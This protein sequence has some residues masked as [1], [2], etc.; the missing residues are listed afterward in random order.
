MEIHLHVYICVLL[1]Q[2][3]R[4]LVRNAT[5]NIATSCKYFSRVHILHTLNLPALG[6]WFAHLPIHPS[7]FSIHIVRSQSLIYVP[8]RILHGSVS[9]T[10]PTDHHS[11]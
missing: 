10:A 9:T 6:G 2:K 11:D 4:F 3:G 8:Y 5:R 7:T 1:E